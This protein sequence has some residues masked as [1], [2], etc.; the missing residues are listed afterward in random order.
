MVDTAAVCFLSEIS[1]KKI[2]S[3]ENQKDST[4]VETNTGAFWTCPPPQCFFRDIVNPPNGLNSTSCVPVTKQTN[5]WR[6]YGSH[7]IFLHLHI[8]PLETSQ[9]PL[10]NITPKH[11]TELTGK[12]FFNLCLFG[13]FSQSDC[14]HLI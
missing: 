3:R 8:D 7:H 2:Q 1:L 9:V 4:E 6:H 12:Q 14:V 13:N 11:P 5:V 10:A